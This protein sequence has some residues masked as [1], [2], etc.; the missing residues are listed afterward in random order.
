MCL[1]N[2]DIA[3]VR[4]DSLCS[5]IGLVQQQVLLTNNRAMDNILFG[6]YHADDAVVI[7]GAWAYHFLSFIEAP[8][9]GF[10]T[11]IGDQGVE[12]SGRQKQRL[13]LACSRIK[14]PAVL[15]LDETIVILITHRHTS[16]ELA[17]IV[18]SVG[19]MAA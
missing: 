18:A 7:R 10:D 17:D 12:L 11:L 3:G 19:K 9:N 13:W 4:F 15:I 14:D 5:Q 8:P 2:D 6:R 1:L 16:L